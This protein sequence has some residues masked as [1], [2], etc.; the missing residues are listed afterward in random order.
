MG[1]SSL[2]LGTHPLFYARELSFVS[3]A[4]D[5]SILLVKVYQKHHIGKDQLVGSLTDTIGGVLGK[6]NEGGTKMCYMT[7]SADASSAI[8]VREATLGKDDGFHLSR[9]TIK[10][11]LAA[12]SRG[13]IDADDR[14]ATDAAIVATEAVNPLSSTPRTVGLLGSAVDTCTNVVTYIQTF[15]TTWSV[16]LQRIEL[17][18][19]I[20]AGVAQVFSAQCSNIF[21]V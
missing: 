3:D 1:Q 16:L 17:F 2:F 18:N 5:R 8:K 10:F 9:I 6:S 4:D 7:C 19:K 11:A 14:Q 21:S 12:Q 15:E 20:V 13:D